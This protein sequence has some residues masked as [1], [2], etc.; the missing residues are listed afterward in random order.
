[1]NKHYFLKNI[2]MRQWYRWDEIFWRKRIAYC[3]Q[4]VV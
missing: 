3:R 1:M 4:M 2:N